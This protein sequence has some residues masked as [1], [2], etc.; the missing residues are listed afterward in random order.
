MTDD[1]LRT[2]HQLDEDLAKRKAVVSCKAE[3][4]ATLERW[5]S[6]SFV[7]QQISRLSEAVTTLALRVPL[8][9]KDVP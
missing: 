1:P 2:L 9:R 5:R 4:L 8:P 7:S 6:I 3:L